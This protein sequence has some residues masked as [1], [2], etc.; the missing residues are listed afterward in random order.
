[1]AKQRKKVPTLLIL[2]K[3]KIKQNYVEFFSHKIVSIL[4]VFVILIVNRL[5]RENRF[6]F[7]GVHIVVQ[8]E[9]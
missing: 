1:M 7:I 2:N 4:K 3:C 8:F 9:Q 5:W 6:T